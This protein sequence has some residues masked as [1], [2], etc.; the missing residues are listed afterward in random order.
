MPGR[1]LQGDLREAVVNVPEAY[2]ISL[3]RV[4]VRGPLHRVAQDRPRALAL[5][6]RGQ[7]GDQRGGT[8]IRTVANKG[9]HQAAHAVEPVRDTR[10]T[11]GQSPRDPHPL[12]VRYVA[13]G[14]HVVPDLPREPGRNHPLPTPEP[15]L[16]GPRPATGI[17]QPQVVVLA[18]PALHLERPDRRHV[19]ERRRVLLV[20]QR[21]Q[22]VGGTV[23]DL[24]I[25]PDPGLARRHFHTD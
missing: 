25:D 12:P 6:A 15:P 18:P 10:R 5:A 17:E 14:V 13:E 16:G 2:A 4:R 1:A 22:R 20:R 3:D 9:E 8:R 24:L 19:D 23:P 21:E 11:G 7:S